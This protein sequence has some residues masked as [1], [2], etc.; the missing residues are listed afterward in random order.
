MR[1]ALF[2]LMSIFYTS[3]SLQAGLL[4][5]TDMNK[6]MNVL[7]VWGGLSPR[8]SESYCRSMPLKRLEKFAGCQNTIYRT[9]GLTAE[10]S[11]EICDR[12]IDPLKLAH[13][14]VSTYQYGHDPITAEGAVNRC[15]SF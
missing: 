14:F 4:V 8:D 9:R 11:A 10:K 12:A 6:C 5:H 2:V 1:K 15:R 3:L 13:C 7:N